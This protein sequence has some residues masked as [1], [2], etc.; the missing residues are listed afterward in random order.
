MPI[1]SVRVTRS[2]RQQTAPVGYAQASRLCLQ[3]Q[4]EDQRTCP[5]HFSIGTNIHSLAGY[6]CVG[7]LLQK[8]D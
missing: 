2:L 7:Q 3:G 4:T 5:V 8:R 6:L 1:V